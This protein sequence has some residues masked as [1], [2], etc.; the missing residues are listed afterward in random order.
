MHI[1]ALD[2]NP[3][4][5]RGV[6]VNESGQLCDWF[7]SRSPRTARLWLRRVLALH[8][9]THLVVSPL[10]DLPEEVQK[11]IS[12]LAIQPT[13]LSPTL[14]RRLYQAARPWNLPRK[15]LRARLLAYFHRHD[16][17]PELLTDHLRD[18]EHQLA[19][20]T[21]ETDLTH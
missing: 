13:W 16:V 11:G 19:R 5:G 4:G 20:E 6:L 3:W 9:E 2:F 21:L 8:P 7:D 17:A 10:D 1:V 12:D 14:M 15:L 18:F